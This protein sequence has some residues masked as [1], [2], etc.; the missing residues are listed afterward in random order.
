M[1]G[2]S[3]Q[4]EPRTVAIPKKLYQHLSF[5]VLLAI[6]LGVAVGY[7]FPKVGVGLQ[8]VSKTFINLIKMIIAPIIFC[9]IVIGI[10]KVQNMKQFGRI[11]GKALL[12][13]LTVT[14]FALLIGIVV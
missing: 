10:G 3:H 6:V 14:T 5:Q 1:A 9:T 8:A 2:I 12:Y 13:F 4:E 7:F 11:G